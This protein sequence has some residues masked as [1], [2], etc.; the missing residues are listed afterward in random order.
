MLVSPRSLLRVG[1]DDEAAHPLN[2]YELAARLSYFFWSSM[3]DEELFSLVAEHKLQKD[4]VFDA[5]V[6]RMLSDPKARVMVENFAGQWLQIRNLKTLNPDPGQFLDFD[7]ALHSAMMRETELF[8]QTIPNEDSSLPTLSMSTS[9]SSMNAWRSTT[10]SKGFGRGVPPRPRDR[11]PPR[12]DLDPGKHHDQHLK[13]DPDLA[14]EARQ[15]NPWSEIPSAPPPPDVP[16]LLEGKDA[17][18]SGSAW[19][20]TGLTRLRFG[21]RPGG[22]A[23]LR[24]RELRPHRC[25]ARAGRGPADRPVGRPP[26]GPDVSRARGTQG[27]PENQGREFARCPVEK[28][29]T[30]ARG[31]DLQY[32]EKYAV[33]RITDTLT[34]N[35]YRSTCFVRG[36]IKSDTFRKHKDKRDES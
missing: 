31:H 2:G 32:P 17:K 15:V 9:P 29:L 14:R 35:Q 33:D 25:L 6:R 24:L 28:M 7:E 8:L 36:I 26:L 1:Y 3:P 23:W 30:Y 12:W 27:D 22:P 18:L 10:A 4:D 21:P 16:E 20:N 13:P 11:L 19:N 5:Q 34:S